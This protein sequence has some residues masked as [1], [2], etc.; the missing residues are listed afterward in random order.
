ME[1]F[2]INGKKTL[3][4]SVKISGNKNEAL[5]VIAAC[6]LTTEPVILRNVPRIGDVETM[7]DIMKS[8]GAI[9]RELERNTLEIQCKNI[10]HAELDQRKCASLRAALLLAG[11]LIT[12][13]NRVVLPPPGG[14]VIGRRRLDTHFLAFTSLGANVSVV[15]RNYVFTRKELCGQDIFLDEQSVT[16]TENALMAAVMAKG[17]T[18]IRN[19]ACEP[20]VSGLAR[21]L[22]SMGAKIS[23]VGTNILEIEGVKQL[24]GVDHTIG[25]D[26]LEAGGYIVLAAITGSEITIKDV[27]PEDLQVTHSTFKKLGITYEI[28][29]R[30]ILVPARQK[31][32]IEPDFAGEIPKIDDGTWPAFPSDLMSIVIVAATQAKGTVLIFEKMYNGRMFF[33]DYL[34]AMG[35]QIVL[36]DPH[37]AVIVGKSN[38][39]GANMQSPDIRAGMALIIAA[40][41]A[42]GKSSIYNIRQIDRGYENLEAKL[43]GLGAD[44]KRVTE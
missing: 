30:N 41:C 34:I 23:G 3:S 13:F 38:L 32:K 28:K 20:H 26:Y 29:G 27:N 36:C 15:N 12:R 18:I 7:L 5:P 42:K 8:Q 1:K 37:R 16:A 39:Y 4:G 33:V 40:L 31:L 21:M 19:A 14:D 2:L 9:V 11:P 44:I 25:S 22:N 10:N 24:S 43:Q 35:A 6:L 17:R